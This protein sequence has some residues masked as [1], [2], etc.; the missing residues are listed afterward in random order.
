MPNLSLNSKKKHKQGNQ[1]SYGVY[2]ETR[3]H[4]EIPI[5]SSNESLRAIFSLLNFE[6]FWFCILGV[7]VVYMTSDF[8]TKMMN[9]KFECKDHQIYIPN[10]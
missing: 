8:T 4:F 10:C 6:N 1:L 3:Y 2:N 7:V 9:K 5:F